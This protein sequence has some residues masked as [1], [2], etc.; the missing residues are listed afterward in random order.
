MGTGNQSINL[1]PGHCNALYSGILHRVN[2]VYYLVM[3]MSVYKVCSYLG[4][5]LSPN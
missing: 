2:P 3:N 1:I 4:C 5:M